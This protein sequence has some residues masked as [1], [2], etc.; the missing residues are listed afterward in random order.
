M[1][2]IGSLVSDGQYLLEARGG[3]RECTQLMQCIR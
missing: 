2:R 3:I 1:L